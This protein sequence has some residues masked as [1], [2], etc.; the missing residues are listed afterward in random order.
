V[1][2]CFT[3]GSIAGGPEEIYC[4][5]LIF[6]FFFCSALTMYDDGNWKLLIKNAYLATGSKQT[7][8]GYLPSGQYFLFRFVETRVECVSEM[9]LITKASSTLR[10]LFC[11]L[12]C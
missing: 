1:H 2:L 11:C 4:S 9:I 10:C 5:R 3:A 12:S 8:P 6:L 7:N